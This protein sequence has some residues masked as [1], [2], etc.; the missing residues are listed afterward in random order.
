MSVDVYS[1]EVGGP[2]RHPTGSRL[3]VA[4]GV[5][6]GEDGCRAPAPLNR[7][8]RDGLGTSEVDVLHMEEDSGTGRMADP[9]ADIGR[10]FTPDEKRG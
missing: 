9:S 2:I 7:E 4:P 6:Q 10:G 5:Q 3:W 8:L 1:V